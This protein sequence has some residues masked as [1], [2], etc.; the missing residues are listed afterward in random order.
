MNSGHINEKVRK[1]GGK[2]YFCKRIIV[3]NTLLYVPYFFGDDNGTRTRD[4]QRDRLAFYTTE[5]CRRIVVAG[6]GLE[7]VF[8]D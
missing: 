7:P 6:T 3:R 5:L 8:L 1:E 4:L 2:F